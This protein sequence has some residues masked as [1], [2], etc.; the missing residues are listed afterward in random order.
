MCRAHWSNIVTIGERVC[1]CIAVDGIAYLDIAPSVIRGTI[2]RIAA[3]FF[4]GRNQITCDGI[5]TR[6]RARTQHKP[7]INVTFRMR[8]FF[9]ILLFSN[10]SMTVDKWISHSTRFDSVTAAILIRIWM[11]RCPHN[12]HNE[13]QWV[14]NNKNPNKSKSI[15]IGI[16]NSTNYVHLWPS[17]PKFIS[18]QNVKKKKT[19]T[20]MNWSSQRANDRRPQAAAVVSNRIIYNIYI[21]IQF[22]ELQT[23]FH[24]SLMKFGAKTKEHIVGTRRRRRW[25]N[26]IQY[27]NEWKS[28]E[29]ERK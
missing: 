1:V 25:K 24:S 26:T 3:Q 16:I 4:V 18:L 29:T 28:R 8:A 27:T 21:S 2:P 14:H 19:D 22:Y 20:P 11:A 23:W 12:V 5:H 13:R 9:F 17:Q 6:A 10:C 7:V 15:I